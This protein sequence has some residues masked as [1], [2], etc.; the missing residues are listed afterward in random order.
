MRSKALVAIALAAATAIG[1]SGCGASASSS[2]ASKEIVL[3]HMENTPSRVK[4]FQKLADEYNATNP[5]YK[6]NIQVQDWGQVYTKI[7][8]AAQAGKQP[9]I[10]FAIPDFATYVRGLGLGQPVTSVVEDIQKKDG[11]IKASTAP[12]T[13][14]GNVWAVPL[15][16]MVQMLWYRKDLFKAAGINSAPATWSELVADAKK[17]S[18]GK[19]NG[20]AVPSGKNLATDQV[21]YSFMVTGGAANMFTKDGKVSIDNAKTV[22]AFDLYKQL[23]DL[24]PKDAGSYSWPE[25]Q[26]AL[27]SGSAAMAVE[28]G[29]YLAPFQSESGKP[30]SDL[31][32]APIP[33]ADNGGKT[34]SIYYSNGAMVLSKD[35]AKQQGAGK[36]LEWVLD[37]KHYGDF[38]NAEPGLFL[39]VTNNGATESNW[40]QNPVISTYKN[41]VNAMLKQSQTGELFGFVDGQYISSIGDISGQNILAQAVQQMTVNGMSAKNAVT[42]AQQQMQAAISKK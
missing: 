35:K 17:L 38:L 15:Y 18:N 6:V 41:C 34:G 22:A 14:K 1:L 28:K 30:A 16:G 3:W 27:N 19:T 9:D 26:A 7:A 13:D 42:W 40:R 8:A 12:Y 37:P 29:Q 25:P 36:F 32:C 5:E 4:A 10:L 20:I 39:P 21:L 31:G 2:S 11:L 33:V 23:A 24:S